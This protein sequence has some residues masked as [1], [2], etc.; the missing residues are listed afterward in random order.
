MTSPIHFISGLPRSG[1]TLLSAILRQNPRFTAGV[2]SPLVS[3]LGAVQAKMS[4]GEFDSF[5]DERKRTNVL[6][7]V[8]ESYY[9]GNMNVGHATAAPNINSNQVV[10]DTNRVWTGRGAFLGQLYPQSKIICCVR[11]IGWIIDS[12][13]KMLAKNPLHLSRVFNFEPGSSV[14]G[15]VETLMNSEQGLIGLPW[16][17]LREAWFSNSA[18][19]L[20]LIPYT[21]LTKHPEQTVT[22]LYSLLD[23]PLHEHN[24]NQVEYDESTYDEELG[25]PGLHAVKAKVAYQERQP[26]IPPDLFA[27]YANTQFWEKG[28]LNTRGVVIL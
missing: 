22:T 11:E 2:T 13:E 18:S 10:F 19:R 21:S 23:E 26:C 25:M 20:I 17:T 1:S 4:G 28:E 15:R 24:F 12:F 16:I 14:Y 9:A 5:F 27:K 6:R 8:F 3:L 7:G